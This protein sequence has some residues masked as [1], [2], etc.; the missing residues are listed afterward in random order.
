MFERAQKVDRE[1]WNQNDYPDRKAAK[2]YGNYGTTRFYEKQRNRIRTDREGD[3]IMTGAKVSMRDAK[4]EAGKCFNCGNKGH[5]AR[6]C[7]ERKTPGLPRTTLSDGNRIRMVRMEELTSTNAINLTTRESGTHSEEES[8]DEGSEQE[9][10]EKEQLDVSTLFQGL[11]AQDLSSEESNSETATE[12]ID[13]E[14]LQSQIENNGSSLESIERMQVWIEGWRRTDGQGDHQND[15][16]DKVNQNNEYGREKHEQDTDIEDLEDNEGDNNDQDEMCNRQSKP[17]IE[18]EVSSTDQG[19]DSLMKEQSPLRIQGSFL[20]SREEPKLINALPTLSGES[21]R[22]T[23]SLNVVDFSKLTYR[24]AIWKDFCEQRTTDTVEEYQRWYNRM[25]V[26][27]RFCKCY[28]FNQ[29]CWASSGEKWMKHIKGCQQ[30]EKW[31]STKCSIPGHSVASKMTTLI[32]ISE[33]RFTPERTK[34]DEKAKCCTYELCTHEFW[35]HG[36]IDVP[37]WAC[38]NETCAEHYAMKAK[39]RSRPMLPKV[40][41]INNSR[42]P[43]LRKGC[44]CGFDRRHLLHR[45]LVTM[46]QCPDDK[47]TEHNPETTDV[48]D[49]DQEVAI[50]RKE[51]QDATQEIRNL[52]GT[53]I[54]IRR[55]TTEGPV[56]QMETTIRVNDKEEKAIIDSG[57]DINY[58]NYEWCRQNGIRHKSHGYGKMKAYDG[59]YVTGLIRKASIMLEI[60]GKKRW[61]TF[62]VLT[63]TGEDNTVLGMPWLQDE[64]L[65]I[66]WKIREVKIRQESPKS[67]ST[68]TGNEEKTFAHRSAASKNG[69]QGIGITPTLM[70]DPI[71]AGR[72]GHNSG[73]RQTGRATLED[74]LSDPEQQ[75]DEY[76]QRMQEV[77]TKL[78]EQLHEFAGVFC[79][80]K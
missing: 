14:E 79:K 22:S 20:S 78:P 71:S 24:S 30:C 23:G 26:M 6:N 66:D 10:I 40:T 68:G 21:T 69:S 12:A 51:I 38:F 16:D 41:L 32:D 76:R 19:D 5:Y 48:Y 27:N 77:L 62:C 31:S 72:G 61:Q 43:C 46:R 45:E 60:Q 17:G 74:T 33:R 63:E 55:T 1:L 49:L 4:K 57:A 3:V 8:E 39:N 9:E 37:W 35:S 50:F 80:K 25:H 34:N 58:V 11:T 28:G 73:L 15:R 53:V 2:P 70:G 13:W 59:T 54:R 67:L 47:C 65:E 7:R 64:N 44:I 75:E 52:M 36:K 29:I 56:Q 18:I 42:C